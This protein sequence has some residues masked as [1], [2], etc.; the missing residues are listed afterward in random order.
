V[1]IWTFLFIFSILSL[2]LTTASADD[3]ESED[4]DDENEWGEDSGSI[5][6][7]LMVASFS[8]V[9][10]RQKISRAKLKEL[11]LTTRQYGQSLQAT[12]KLHMWVS[13]IATILAVYHAWLM[14]ADEGWFEDD[15]LTG[16]IP[17]VAMIY[18]TLSGILLWRKLPDNWVDR[19]LRKR[20]RRVHVQRWITV[21][22]VLG[23]L[24]HVA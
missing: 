13:A 17:L 19:V 2:I 11:G 12:L 24:I 21:L 22:F 15:S 10:L 1:R 16:Y 6:A 20:A 3:D 4:D 5:A 7:W 23:L 14:I 9:V 18:L 8:Y